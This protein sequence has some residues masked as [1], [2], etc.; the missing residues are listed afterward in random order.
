VF[1]DFLASGWTLNVKPTNMITK[2]FT[3][4]ALFLLAAAIAA[5]CSTT[6]NSSYPPPRNNGPVI[7][8]NG[9]NDLPPGHNKRVYGDRSARNH[10]PGHNKRYGYNVRGYYPLIIIRTPDI[11][12]GRFSDGRYYHRNR[13]GF[14]YWMGPDRRFYLDDRYLRDIDYN[15]REYNDWYGRKNNYY[16]DKR[17]RDDDDDRDDYK[18]KHKGRKH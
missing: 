3:Q 11:L 18:Q 7:I 9:N 16:K 5:S 10:A 17:D 15:E 14:I 1:Y 13:D 8:V 2:T 12:I 6:R 4:A